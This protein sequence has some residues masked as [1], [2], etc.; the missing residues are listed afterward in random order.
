[1]Q[2]VPTTET[3][4]DKQKEKKNLMLEINKIKAELELIKRELSESVEAKTALQNEVIGGVKVSDLKDTV[5]NNIRSKIRDEVKI[6]TKDKDLLE[7]GTENKKREFN[8]LKKDNES[9]KHRVN[10]LLEDK[11]KLQNEIAGLQ[12]TKNEESKNLDKE[13]ELKITLVNNL[14]N[15]KKD[16][17][18]KLEDYESEYESKK[19]DLMKQEIRLANK[20][21][22]L[23][24]Y[25]ARLRAKYLELMPEMEIVV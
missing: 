10:S 5:L 15:Q 3:A 17:L 19:S 20:G 25:E 11:Q 18:K 7:Q 12:V 21:S 6:L 1:M 24:I 14:D 13:I 16:A 4:F 2:K 23:A 8:K 9:H 22:D